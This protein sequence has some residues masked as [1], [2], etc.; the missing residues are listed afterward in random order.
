[1]GESLFTCSTPGCGM[2]CDNYGEYSSHLKTHQH[3]MKTIMDT[4]NVD[5]TQ[6]QIM[7]ENIESMLNAVCSANSNVGKSFVNEPVP[8]LLNPTDMSNNNAL[9]N[10]S[11]DSYLSLDLETS[12]SVDHIQFNQH[13]VQNTFPDFQFDMSKDTQCIQDSQ[14]EQVDHLSGFFDMHNRTLNANTILQSTQSGM[15]SLSAHVADPIVAEQKCNNS[16]I[17]NIH[18][19]LEPISVSFDSQ[20][21]QALEFPG[22]EFGSVFDLAQM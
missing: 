21:P 19:D 5:A 6:T 4:F 18:V 15:P 12:P 9:E 1:M 7:P 11:V 10:I 3:E 20:N 13:I 8:F 16:N 22:D 2:S 14:H 17:R